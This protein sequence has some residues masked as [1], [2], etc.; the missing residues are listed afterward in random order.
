MRPTVLSGSFWKPIWKPQ[1]G[2]V[3]EEPQFS[4]MYEEPEFGNMYEELALW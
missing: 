4:N 2:N 3:D 1:F